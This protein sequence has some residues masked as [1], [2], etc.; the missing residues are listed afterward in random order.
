M[1]DLDAR[2]QQA[3]VEVTQL[4]QAPDN[5]AKLK[6][7]ALYK[8]ATVGDCTGDRP[9]MLDFVGRA[10]YDAWKELAGTSMDEA[11]EKYIALV[12]ELKAADKK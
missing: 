4:S 10:K 11:K 1:S 2:F 12:E 9:G 8:Q 7:Y 6:L 3:S 5:L